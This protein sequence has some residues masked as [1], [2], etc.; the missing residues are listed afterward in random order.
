MVRPISISVLTCTLNSEAFLEKALR[1]VETQSYQHIEHIINDSYS[2]DRT[3]EIIEKY[4]DRN[5]NRY[6][7]KLIETKPQGVAN[8]LNRAT[9]VA[10]GEVIHCL[11]S[12]DYYDNSASLAKAA[13]YFSKYPDLVWLTG[14][15]LIEIKGV[16][17]TI[18]HSHLLRIKPATAISI[19]NFVHHENTFA[20]RE[21]I[22]KYGGFCEDLTMNVEYR[23]WLRMM[24]NHDPMV[25]NDQFTVFIIHKGSTSTGNILQFTKAILRGFNTLKQEKVFPFIGYY[26]NRRLYKSYKEIFTRFYF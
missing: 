6:P 15:F 9:D 11:H 24:Q 17:I 20:K 13:A 7:I 4:I 14:N 5:K 23:L 26:E 12:D 16:K 18:P 2:T 10:T 8:A 21:V 25:V 3:M 1:S 19:T 22:K